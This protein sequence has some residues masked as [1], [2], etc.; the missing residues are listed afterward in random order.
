MPFRA[1]RAQSQGDPD[2]WVVVD[3]DW[4]LHRE[5]SLFLDALR[6]VDRS[7]NTERV[8]AGRVALFLNWCEQVGVSW[9][10]PEFIELHAFLR[11]LVSTPSL[12]ERS[13]TPRSRPRSKSTANAVFTA[14]SE[15]LRFAS[16]QGWV[17]TTVPA[18]LTRREYLQFTPPGF[19]PGEDG[20]FRSVAVRT[21]KYRVGEERP[22]QSLT[23]AQITQVLSCLRHDRDR[24]L[25]MLL[26]TSGMRIGE[27]LG[28]AREDVHFLARSDALGCQVAGAHLHVRRRRNDNGALAKSRYPRTI[29]V[30]DVVVG[31]YADYQ[32]ERDRHGGAVGAGLA[33]AAQAD[34]VFVN[35]FRA[36]RG[37]PMTY[38][39]VK[40]LFDRLARDCGFAV[41]PHMLRH[42][43]ATQWV[44]AGTG[45]DV[46]QALLG[47]VS[48][49]STSVY[50]HATRERM[51]SAVEHTAAVAA[52]NAAVPL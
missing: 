2:R 26:L 20:Q 16:T 28:L 30:D 11:W 18:M 23:P 13:A 42:T 5:A 9:A 24:F 31:V 3:D 34:S 32:Y 45:P 35:L 47:H 8:Y 4:V 39:T 27:A 33:G 52:A 1:E 49:T 38:A 41:R 17:D 10:E 21:I 25:I 36:P 37:R 22:P 51:R 46:V 12:A 7:P 19:N 6:A 44:E 48:A 29:P 40:D 43:A 50:V 14:V 15:F